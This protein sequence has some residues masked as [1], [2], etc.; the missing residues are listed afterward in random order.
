M[1]RLIEKNNV[2]ES[3]IVRAC[4]LRNQDLAAGNVICKCYFSIPQIYNFLH[5]IIFNNS[6]G[7]YL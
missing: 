3:D 5:K 2:E 4:D 6:A 7:F 1:K